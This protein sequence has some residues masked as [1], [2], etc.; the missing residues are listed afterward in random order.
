M[1]QEIEIEFKNLLTK[2]EFNQVLKYFLTN[3]SHKI[4]QVNHY[5]ETKAMD[6]KNKQAALRIREKEDSYQLTL[7][8]PNPEGAGL[9]ETHANLTE[10]E[11]SDWIN[12]EVKYNQKIVKQ[13]QQLDIDYNKLHYGGQLKTVRY[14]FPYKDTTIVLDHSFYND[15]EDYELELEAK[16]EA[17]GKE[18]F[19]DILHQFDIPLRKTDNKIKRFYTTIR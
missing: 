15:V 16:D 4:V 1:S 6:L 12:D 3:D 13:L 9:L 19:D 14:E 18:I 10:D 5:F 8:Q 11:A 2:K 17:Y 7:K